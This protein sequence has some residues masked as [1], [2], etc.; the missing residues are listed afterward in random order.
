[1]R[2]DSTFKEYLTERGITLGTL[3]FD[4]EEYRQWASRFNSAK[5]QLIH[6]TADA[7]ELS[8]ENLPHAV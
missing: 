5:F 7:E 3:D 6:G 4:S 8:D 1:M 2:I